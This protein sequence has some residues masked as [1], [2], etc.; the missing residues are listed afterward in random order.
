[1]AQVVD[2]S[3]PTLGNIEEFNIFEVF[4]A[5]CVRGKGVTDAGPVRNKNLHGS[6]LRDGHS[7]FL[8]SEPKGLRL[9]GRRNGPSG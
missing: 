5:S 7:F 4:F 3:S 2:N 6:A 9:E 1:M 8:R